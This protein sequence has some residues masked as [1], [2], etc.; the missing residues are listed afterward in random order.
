MILIGSVSINGC[1][2]YQVL[3]WAV[4]PKLVKGKN[5]DWICKS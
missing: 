4:F 1:Q 3:L 5:V 2:R